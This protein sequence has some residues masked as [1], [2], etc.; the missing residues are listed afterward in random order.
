MQLGDLCFFYHSVVGK[1]IMGIVKVSKTH[2][3]DPSDE[4]GKFVMV[5]MS[6]EKPLKHPV[7]L[8]KIK[9]TQNLQDLPLLKQSRLS[10]MPITLEQWQIIMDLGI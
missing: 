8:E 6:Y 3:P 4:S 9:A 1:Q 10:V 5:E 7:S 2:M